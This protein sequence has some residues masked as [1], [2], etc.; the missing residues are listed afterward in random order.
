MSEQASPVRNVGTSLHL[1]WCS[2]Q[3]AKWAV[4]H[5]HYSRSLPPP[6]RV[7]IGV[8][9]A[10]TFT[11][12][13][14][15]SRG[16]G[17]NLLRPYGLTNIEGAELTR[18]AL[19]SHQAPVSRIV[20]IA[21]QLVRRR[22]PG[23]RLLVSFADPAEGHVG[24]IYQA[25]GWVYVGKSPA[26]RAY[27]DSTGRVWHDRMISPTGRR[28]VFGEYRP[29]LRP[30]DCTLIRLPGK[31]RYLY[32]LDN[33]MR[34]QIEPLRQPYPKRARSDTSDTPADQAGEGGAAPTLA[35]ADVTA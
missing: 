5:W 3:A 31:H 17:A 11:G 2:Y 13:V 1:D 8:W 10:D 4:E 20:R 22:C 14:L 12:V 9:E 19:T 33:A 29:V 32:P 16:A 28:K 34:Q 18:I 26:S 23:L 35:L 7:Q 21:T 24:V 30:D 25:S 15:F 27:A 6:P